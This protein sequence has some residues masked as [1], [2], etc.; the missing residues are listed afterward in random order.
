VIVPLGLAG[1]GWLAL[2]NRSADEGE[3]LLLRARTAAHSTDYRGTLSTKTFYE[4]RSRVIQARAYYKAG[5]RSRIEYTSPPLNGVILGN[6]GR[7]QWRFD[8]SRHTV[9]FNAPE[10][11]REPLS[12]SGRFRLLLENYHPHREGTDRIAGRPVAIIHLHR[13]E[14]SGPFKR[15]WIDLEKAIVLRCD[16]FDG[17]GRLLMRTVYNAIA[18]APQP[19][20][21]FEPPRKAKTVL[22]EKWP[23]PMD[24]SGLSKAVGFPVLLPHYLPPGY[25][26]DGSY[27]DKCQCGCG[28]KATYSRYVDGLSVISVFQCAHCMGDGRPCTIIDSGHSK[29]ANVF[30]RHMSFVIVGEIPQRELQ[31]MADSLP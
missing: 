4:G 28:M 16:E 29:I 7:R 6:D 21:L 19:D 20:A 22:K 18:F 12:E 15:L 9:V 17:D 8:S 10:A 2:R 24:L 1:L 25:V 14:G 13:R 23:R 30:H 27:L 3:W 11:Q 26:Y 31:K 5:G